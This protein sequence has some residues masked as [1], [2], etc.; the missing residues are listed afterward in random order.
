MA[1]TRL[2]AV[3]SLGW[4]VPSGQASLIYK[5]DSC[6]GQDPSKSSFPHIG[7]RKAFRDGEDIVILPE[8]RKQLTM[9]EERTKVYLEKYLIWPG[10]CSF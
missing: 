6:Q 2:E 3:S 7:F 1:R 8:S 9:F 10:V 5:K 4:H